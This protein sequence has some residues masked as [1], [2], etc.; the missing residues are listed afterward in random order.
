MSD[1]TQRGRAG[2]LKLVGDS[3]SVDVVFGWGAW[4]VTCVG[5]L[6]QHSGS[7]H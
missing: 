5:V 6:L 1:H 3:C 7:W 2:I 4:P